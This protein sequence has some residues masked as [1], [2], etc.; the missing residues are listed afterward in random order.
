MKNLKDVIKGM[1]ALST[2]AIIFIL[3]SCS[4]EDASPSNAEIEAL[5]KQIAEFTAG[6]DTTSKNLA[7]FDELDFVVFNNQQWDRIKESHSQDVKVYWPD[8]HFTTG[9]DK[10]IEDM[11]A[12]FVFAPDTRIT[13]H[14]I[15]LGSGNKTAVTGVFEGTFTMPMPIGNGQFIQPTG[16]A[17]KIPMATVGIWGPDGTMFEEHLFFDNQT[18][19]KQIGL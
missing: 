4:K 6:M 18:Y 19:M 12:L 11:K 9:I 5:K 15:I 13:S 8:G 16:K 7:K 10:H 14:P 1:V 3:S 2:V 17:F